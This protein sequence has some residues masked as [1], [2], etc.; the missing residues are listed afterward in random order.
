MLTVYRRKTDENGTYG[1]KR[2]MNT[3]YRKKL[4]SFKR[5][6]IEGMQLTL[7]YPLP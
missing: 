5:N 2:N 7:K 4:P 3:F 6:V 1:S